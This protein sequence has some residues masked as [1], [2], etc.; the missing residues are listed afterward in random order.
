[1]LVG[2]VLMIVLQMLFPVKASYLH[3]E[4]ISQAVSYLISHQNPDGGWGGAPSSASSVY[5]TCMA[6]W[7]ITDN[8]SYPTVP[9]QNAKDY[10]LSQ[11]NASGVWSEISMTVMATMTLAQVFDEVNSTVVEWVFTAQLES[12]TW[13][14]Y[15]AEGCALIASWLMLGGISTDDMHIAKSINYI[16]SQQQPDHLWGG[17]GAAVPGRI[18]TALGLARLNVT[19]NSTVLE[20]AIDAL[21]K[22]QR[23]NGAFYST[24][25]GTTDIYATLWAVSALMTC[26]AQVLTNVTIL[27]KI[28]A[29]TSWLLTQQGTGGGFIDPFNGYQEAPGTTCQGAISLAIT[30]GQPAPYGVL[31]ESMTVSWITA[32]TFATIAATLSRKKRESSWNS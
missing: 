9:V 21:I 4:E 7:S 15:S 6:I 10:L 26:N 23:V 1:M 29:A 24:S 19:M 25:P 30:G 32:A 28:N 11:R 20:P 3:T 5:D 18:V 31:S 12:G 27:E 17:A 22:Y 8:G 14:G 13:P 16:I 2:A